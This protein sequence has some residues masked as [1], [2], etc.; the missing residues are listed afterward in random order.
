MIHFE[1]SLYI[2]FSH[3]MLSLKI[4]CKNK[5]FREHITLPINWLFI[6]MLG[7]KFHVK[8]YSTVFVVKI[9]V[10]ILISKM[11]NLADDYMY[12]LFNGKVGDGPIYFSLRKRFG[13]LN[14]CQLWYTEPKTNLFHYK[15]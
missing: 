8:F 10:F 11:L 1:K 4:I 5:S 14:H 3:S 7:F 2:Y 12:I 15:H 13:Q 6:F 9:S